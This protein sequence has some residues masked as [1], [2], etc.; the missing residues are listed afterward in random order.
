MT[1]VWFP[2][3]LKGQA[4]RTWLVTLRVF[5]S[6]SANNVQ[7][8]R[9]RHTSE[10]KLTFSEPSGPST[11]NMC[12]H[13]R[14]YLQEWVSDLVDLL[15]MFGIRSLTFGWFLG[16]LTTTRPSSKQLPTTK[17]MKVTF[18]THKKGPLLIKICLMVSVS[19]LCS[20]PRCKG[21]SGADK[22]GQS[23]SGLFCFI[24]VYCA[25]LT[26]LPTC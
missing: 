2:W 21:D 14:W 6:V 7:I 18:M 26:K 3:V 22:V 15:H 24:S 23:Y 17:Q 10:R 20:T 9:T 8:K 16:M 5:A 11:P 12:V 25:S 13:C 1:K 19:V 4:S